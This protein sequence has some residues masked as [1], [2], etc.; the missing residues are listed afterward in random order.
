[1]N[2]S[3][4]ISGFHK[5]SAAERLNIVKTFSNLND[6]TVKLFENTG[7]IPI[8]LADN[9]VENVIG[10]M[11]IPLGIATNMKINGQDTL[12]PMATE[13]SSVVA[14]VC[15]AARQCYDNGGF[16]TSMSGSLMIAQIQ[17]VNITNPEYCLSLIH[18]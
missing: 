9:L 16:T 15:N 7:N 18:I 4:R 17:L 5:M 10:T 8:D 14:A 2:K 3:S 11:N 13:E 1:M 6:E 12:I